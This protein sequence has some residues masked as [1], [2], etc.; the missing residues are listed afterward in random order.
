[1]LPVLL[2]AAVWDL[3][4]TAGRYFGGQ[5]QSTPMSHE[6]Q[7]ISQK[8]MGIFYIFLK[9]PGTLPLA[10]KTPVAPWTA[11]SSSILYPGFE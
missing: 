9:S 3:L 10:M 8:T 6:G 5:I 2:F 1:M 4:R 11:H 7:T